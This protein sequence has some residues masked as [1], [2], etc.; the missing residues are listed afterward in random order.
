ME[1]LIIAVVLLI[2]ITTYCCCVV[3]ARADKE[4]LKYGEKKEN[5]FKKS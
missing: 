3:S 2:A 5:S 1:I 4:A